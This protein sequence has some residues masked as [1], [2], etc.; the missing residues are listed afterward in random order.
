MMSFKKGIGVFGNR[1]GPI[2]SFQRT[3]TV[4]LY[5]PLNSD[6]YAYYHGRYTLE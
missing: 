5:G 2:T 3:Q 1:F 4:W 6:R